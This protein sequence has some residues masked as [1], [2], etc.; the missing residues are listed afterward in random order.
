MR[1]IV[2]LLLNALAVFL[3]G[4][5]VPGVSVTSYGAAI[6]AALLLAIAN[7]LLRPILIV[8]TLPITLVTLG[9]FILVINAFVFM[10]ALNVVK[11]VEVEGFGAAFLGWLVYSILSFLIQAIVLGTPRE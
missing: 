10:L 5:I 11:G 1:M 8:L 4:R 9:L 3:T 7:T 2:V 6:V